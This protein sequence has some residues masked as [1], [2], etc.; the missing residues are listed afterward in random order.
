MSSGPCCTISSQSSY[1]CFALLWSSSSFLPSVSSRIASMPL[2]RVVRLFYTDQTLTLDISTMRDP[3]MA[4]SGFGRMI[5]NG[6]SA[7]PQRA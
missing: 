3:A 7:R 1:S 6:N 2:S 5:R 4:R